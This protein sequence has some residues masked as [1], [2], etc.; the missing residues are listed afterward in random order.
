[1]SDDVMAPIRSEQ[2]KVGGWRGVARLGFNVVAGVS[3]VLF[4][5]CII[6]WAMASYVEPSEQSLSFLEDCHLSLFGHPSNIIDATAVLFNIKDNGPYRGSILYFSGEPNPPTVTGFGY[7]AGI[8]YRMIRWP[9]GNVLW[10][11][12]LHMAYPSAFFLILPMIWGYGYRR[13]VRKVKTI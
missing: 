13:R 1:M 3:A 8:Y 7:T 9:D 2:V 11:F 4:C 5:L 10:T 6:A 12:A